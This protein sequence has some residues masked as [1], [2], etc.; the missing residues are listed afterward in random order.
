[1]FVLFGIIGL[2]IGGLIG[3]WTA[4]ATI[5]GFAAGVFLA[6]FFKVIFSS[7]GSIGVGFDACLLV[8]LIEGI[9]GGF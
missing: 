3:G 2:V 6:L 9:G 1:M 7:R 8:I 4:V 5:G